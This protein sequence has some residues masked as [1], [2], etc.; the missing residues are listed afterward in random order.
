MGCG[1][2]AISRALARLRYMAWVDTDELIASRARMSIPEIFK[3]EGEAGFR[4][5]ELEVVE[6]TVLEPRPQV[7]ATGGGAFTQRFAR[8]VL[9]ST[10]VVVY[11]RASVA[12]LAARVA[13]GSGRPLLDCFTDPE[14]QIKNLLNE[15]EIYYRLADLTLDVDQG[16][17]ETIAEILAEN[18]PA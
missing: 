5:R 6:D 16:N 18:L 1:K 3:L 15:R 7:I 9:L 8:Q 2:T 12:T 4:S 14:S 13:K 17:I 11:L 10:S